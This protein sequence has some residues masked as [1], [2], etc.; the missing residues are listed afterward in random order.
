MKHAIVR[1]SDLASHGTQ[2]S[3]SSLSAGRGIIIAKLAKGENLEKPWEDL[4]DGVR[5]SVSERQ[6]RDFESG[7]RNVKTLFD[8]DLHVRTH[9]GLADPMPELSESTFK[10][11]IAKWA[12]EI[13]DRRL[14]EVAVR[15]KEAADLAAS[16]KSNDPD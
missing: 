11:W 6:Y 7:V 15:A 1:L 4:D 13:V 8:L 16:I 14:E 10:T 2:R 3:A 5:H 9:L 12:N